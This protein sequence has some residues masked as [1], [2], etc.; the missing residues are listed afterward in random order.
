MSTQSIVASLVVLLIS[1]C[2]VGPEL[3]E[4]K[5]AHGPQGA[6]MEITLKGK[7]IRGNDIAGEL[8]ALQADGVLL[9][10]SLFPPR[11]DAARTVVMVP[12]EMM[13]YARLEQMGRVKVESKGEEQDKIY[14]ERLRLVSRFPQGLSDHLL[15]KLLAHAGQDDVVVPFREEN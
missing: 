7:P 15:G 14:K 9:N 10:V 2:T 1:S 5:P 8:L 11:P 13:K 6:L 3:S 4:F 12:Y